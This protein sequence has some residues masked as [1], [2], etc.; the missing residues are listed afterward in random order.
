M[1]QSKGIPKLSMGF[2]HRSSSM[3]GI[4]GQRQTVHGIPETL[5]SNRG[6]RDGK[7]TGKNGLPGPRTDLVPAPGV[8]NPV[9]GRKHE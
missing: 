9:S 3:R 5:T 2:S 7:Q 1:S 6:H 4:A 8:A